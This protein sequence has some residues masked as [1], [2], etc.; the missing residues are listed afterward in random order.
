MDSRFE[1][2][3]TNGRI[4]IDN[5]HRQP[6][7]VVTAL[8]T[9]GQWSYPMPLPG[10]IADGHLAMLRHFVTC[11]RTG[12]PSGSEG[13]RGWEVLAVVDAALRSMSSGRR[14]PVATNGRENPFTQPEERV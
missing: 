8:G 3:G 5:L 4:L 12:A 7:Q 11:L 14:E 6:I 1:V 9:G 10:M 2:F 13:E